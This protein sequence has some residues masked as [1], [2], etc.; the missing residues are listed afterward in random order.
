M[1]FIFRFQDV[2]I[3]FVDMVNNLWYNG[4]TY[5]L[6][7]IT[8]YTKGE[9]KMKKFDRNQKIGII[10]L[11]VFVVLLIVFFILGDLIQSGII[12]DFTVNQ[13]TQGVLAFA[14]L[15][16]LSISILFWGKHFNSKGEYKIGKVFT[17]VSVALLIFGILQALLSL[18]GCY[19][20]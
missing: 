13:R 20:A 2:Y 4:D 19:G 6:V 9:N 1:D 10:T 12:P 5:N 16:P 18:I 7:R 11:L 15:L 8:M 14:F 3:S 17:F